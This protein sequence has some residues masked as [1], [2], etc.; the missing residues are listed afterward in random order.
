[1]RATGSSLWLLGVC[2]A[3]L[4]LDD[5]PSPPPRASQ[6][7]GT[8]GHALMERVIHG[9]RITRDQVAAA[10][11]EHGVET[12][13]DEALL[14]AR[15]EAFVEWWSRVTYADQV[16]VWTEVPIA[17][18][19]ESQVARLLPSAGHRDYS[20]A[21]STELVLTVDAI[22]LTRTACEP[23]ILHVLDWKNFQEHTDTE[24][25]AA[26]ESG[27][28]Q[29]A[30]AGL[31]V[32]SLPSIGSVQGIRSHL[33]AGALRVLVGQVLVGEDGA[34]AVDMESLGTQAEHGLRELD[35]FDLAELAV[36]MAALGRTSASPPRPGDHCRRCPGRLA[37][38]ETMG[39][40]AE[41]LGHVEAIIPSSALTRAIG[42]KGAR[43]EQVAEQ[44][45]Q[46][47]LRGVSVMVEDDVD[48]IRAWLL[49]KL[50]AELAAALTAAA[51]EH[52]RTRPV[53]LPSGKRLGVREHT[54]RTVRLT[55]EG[56][57]LIE[58]RLGPVDW[59][60]VAPRSMSKDALKAAIR[61]SLERTTG[62]S[63]GVAPVL[64]ELEKQAAKRGLLRLS[65]HSRFEVFSSREDD[66]PVDLTPAL[67]ASV[68][69]LGASR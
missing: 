63:R 15:M 56:R 20:A 11:F 14:V 7:L 19:V 62:R 51:R 21:R 69:A 9:E 6:A 49:G 32:A 45:E 48:A 52:A 2:S 57:A 35:T 65:R 29:I 10:A 53:V 1:M 30:L 61:M 58:E 54:E 68:D 26:G 64:R 12:E 37:C 41:A 59:D 55:A 28:L 47:R 16:E 34:R 31:A 66:E 25:R 27:R 4:A 38:E 39:A 8:A 44:L 24:E 33:D 60:E 67:E 18:D 23:R 46:L 17:W 50:F 40:A 42:G 3:W 13:R 5:P 22:A 36:E 43:E